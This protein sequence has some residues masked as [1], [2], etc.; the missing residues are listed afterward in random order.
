MIQGD[1]KVDGVL[2]FGS[3]LRVCDSFES[4]LSNKSC[5]LVWSGNS[6]EPVQSTPLSS[7]ITPTPSPT[8]TLVPSSSLP[9]ATSSTPAVTLTSVPLSLSSSPLPTTT[10]LTSLKVPLA[11]P[12]PI[13]VEGG[14]SDYDK[15]SNKTSEPIPLIVLKR[16]AHVRSSTPTIYDTPFDKPQKRLGEIHAIDVGGETEVQIE[17]LG[18]AHSNVVLSRECLISLNWPAAT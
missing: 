9:P 2:I 16:H 13:L 6:S 12:S 4:A 11:T 7:S 17:G 18:H 8:S 14:N 1:A 5:Q 15:G 10:S 3:D